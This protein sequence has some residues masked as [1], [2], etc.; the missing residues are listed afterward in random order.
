M[1]ESTGCKMGAKTLTAIQ[2]DFSI[3]IAAASA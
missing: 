3:R 1:E 2:M